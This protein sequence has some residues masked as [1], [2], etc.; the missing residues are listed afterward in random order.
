MFDK[1]IVPRCVTRAAAVKRAI[2]KVASVKQL[3]RETKKNG[4]SEMTQNEGK[5]MEM[6]TMIERSFREPEIGTAPETE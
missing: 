5:R 1:D 6:G 2:T 4:L 3:P